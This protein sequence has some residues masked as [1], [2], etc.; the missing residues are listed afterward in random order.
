MGMTATPW[1]LSEREGF[2]HLFEDLHCGPQVADLQ[3][4]K[5]LCHAR[6]LSPPDAE[7]IQGGRVESTGDYSEAGIE[8]ANENRDIWTAGAL[9][10]WRKHGQNRQTVVYAVSIKHARNLVGM[11]N[12]GGIPAGLMLSETPTLERS[13]LIDQFRCGALKALINVGV[14]T[15]GF[16]LPDAACVVLTRPTMSLSLCLHSSPGYRP[17]PPAM[18]PAQ[19]IPMLVG[20]TYLVVQALGQVS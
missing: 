17:P 4:D 13:I 1:R 16:D 18:L 10:F 19:A 14:A 5:W 20:L 9:R 7:K 15:E 12:Q 11:F 8:G 2:D 6:V 3:S